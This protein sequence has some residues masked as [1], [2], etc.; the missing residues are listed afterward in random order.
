MLVDPHFSDDIKNYLYKSKTEKVGTDL[1]SINI[2]RSRDHGFPGMCV[3][4]ESSL[5]ILNNLIII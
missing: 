3:R 4:K 1:V 2:Q 5:N